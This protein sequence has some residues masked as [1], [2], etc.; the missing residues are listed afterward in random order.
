MK[1]NL[2]LLYSVYFFVIQPLIAGLIRQQVNFL[3]LGAIN[4]VAIILIGIL[5]NAIEGK[6]E[7]HA[8]VG[9]EKKASKDS[10]VSFHEHLHAVIKERKKKQEL[11]FPLLLWL[12]ISIAIFVIF[13]PLLW[14]VAVTFGGAVLVGLIIF[15]LITIM[16]RHRFTKRFW[17]LI[18]TKIYLVLLIGSIW[19]IAYDYAQTYT[20]YHATIQ[21]YFAQHLLWEERIPTNTYVFTG[22]GTVLGSGLGTTHTEEPSA[23]DIFDKAVIHPE[24]KNTTGTTPPVVPSVSAGKQTLMDA[25][26]YLIDR[27]DLPLVTSKDIT[28]RYLTKNDPYYAQWRTAYANKLIWSSTNPTKYILCESY[29][30]MKWLLE[31]RPVSYTSSTVINK[32]WTEATTRD[33][34]NGCSKGKVVTDKNL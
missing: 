10:S 5:Y 21:D 6:G 9:D 29:I 33:A 17:A 23:S 19:W 13:A 26:R 15:V 22:E 7:D 30:V 34:L 27:Y 32:F 28:F 4:L 11:R 25:V 31:K 3:R 8:P 16:Y 20:S 14:S 1:K 24:T 2:I 12:I 18:G